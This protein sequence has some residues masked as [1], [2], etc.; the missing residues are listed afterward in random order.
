M[1]ELAQA[2]AEAQAA[3]IRSEQFEK[4]AKQATSEA[5][6]ARAQ[7]E[8]LIADI[9]RI[10]ANITQ[11]D[12]RVRMIESMRAERKA[13]L[14]KRQQPVIRLT[15]ALQTM[16]RRPPVLALAQPG[17][18]DDIVRIR[19]LLASTLPAVRQ[20]TAGLRAE[21]EAGNQ[22]RIE[23][24]HTLAALAESRMNLGQR[25]RELARLE[26]NQ[27]RRSQ[28][29]TEAALS[30]IDRS[31]AFGE[32][33]RELVAR[34]QDRGY[35]A[36]LN[37]ELV[38]LPGPLLRPDTGGLPPVFHDRE[39]PY[40]LPVEGRLITGTGEI[41]EAGVHARGLTFET[42]ANAPV[43]AP[44]SGRV[45]YAGRFRSYGEVIIID[46]GGGWVST[47]TNLNALRVRQGDI[48][49]GGDTIGRSG[50][51]VTVELRYNGHPQSITELIVI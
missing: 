32:E 35:Q 12:L 39:A 25:R 30:E 5:A 24:E 13:R 45:V 34:M 38:R 46:H 7:N 21:V 31:I 48:I 4:Q 20:Q 44:R 3:A 51:Q 29:L 16:A 37:L 2:K 14:A 27:L 19:A 1:S 9:E 18:I 47:I 8:A 40:L 10:E 22:L 15:S 28:G 26:G 50:R 23:A 49:Q 36:K 33:V 42:T 6:R 11:A 43:I 17:S 41:S